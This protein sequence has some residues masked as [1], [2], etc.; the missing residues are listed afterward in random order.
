MVA[1]P[2]LFIRLETNAAVVYWSTNYQ[3]FG[4]ESTP[5]LAPA[6][7]W[8]TVSGPYFLNGGDFEYHEMKSELLTTRFFRLK[9]PTVIYL[10][11]PSPQLS[12][13]VQPPT[14][15]AVLTWSTN[16]IGYTLEATTNLAAPIVWSAVA[17][18]AGTITNSRIEFRQNLDGHTPRQFFRLRWP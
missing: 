18:G 14:Q 15:Q 9:F 2:G 17:D 1:Q 3:G 5:S 12:F 4:L 10:N 16:Y 8:T 11:P 7:T 13:S 6:A